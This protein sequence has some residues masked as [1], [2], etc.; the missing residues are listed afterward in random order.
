MEWKR[1]GLVVMAAGLV[2]VV[3]GGASI[4]NSG[5]I[6]VTDGKVRIFDSSHAKLFVD[7]PSTYNFRITWDGVRVVNDSYSMRAFVGNRKVWEFRDNCGVS[8]SLAPIFIDVSYLLAYC[9][10]STAVQYSYVDRLVGKILSIRG[11][12]IFK[13]DSHVYYISALSLDN[14][15][16][17][18]RFSVKNG[19]S[20]EEFLK[21][22]L[23]KYPN[24]CLKIKDGPDILSF[25]KI[26]TNTLVFRADNAV[27]N[28]QAEVSLT[29][30]L[31]YSGERR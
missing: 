25:Y 12:P 31:T 17:V 2:G 7:K 10:T 6:P 26:L 9:T 22:G 8:Q 1:L 29:G 28:F 23:I 27:C 16:I 14:P 13:D 4:Q 30:K 19:I 15:M 5:K 3:E 24:K 11:Q 20:D 18:R 21:I